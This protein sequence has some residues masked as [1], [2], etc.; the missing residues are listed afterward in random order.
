VACKVYQGVAWERKEQV[1]QVGATSYMYKVRQ[2]GTKKMAGG[3][4]AGRRGKG[5]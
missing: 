5:R 4:K 2:E 1:R 3:K